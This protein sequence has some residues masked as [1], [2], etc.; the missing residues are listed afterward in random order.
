MLLRVKKE[1]VPCGEGEGRVQ[2]RRSGTNS[3]G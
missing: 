3:G 1:G 2:L